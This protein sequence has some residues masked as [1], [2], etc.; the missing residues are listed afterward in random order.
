[1]ALQVARQITLTGRPVAA[2]SPAQQSI[3]PDSDEPLRQDVQ[4][5]PAQELFGRE[6]RAFRHYPL[7]A[8]QF[9]MAVMGRAE[10]VAERAVSSRQFF[11]G[12]N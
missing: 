4:Q 11:T 9:K 6:F 1:M 10:V 12:R 8:P 5:E 2:A 7:R 3:M